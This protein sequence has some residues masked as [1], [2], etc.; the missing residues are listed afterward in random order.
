[1]GRWDQR[2]TF[3]GKEHLGVRDRNGPVR[4]EAGSQPRAALRPP[5]SAPMPTTE[6]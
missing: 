2:E 6:V 1:M 4:S 5:T 3:P